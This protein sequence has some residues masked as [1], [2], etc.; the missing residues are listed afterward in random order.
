VGSYIETRA[1][2][3]H[4]KDYGGDGLPIVLVHGLGGS[5][6]SWN[7]IGPKLA[8]V[9]RTVAFDLPGFGLSPPGKDWELETHADAIV[10][11]IEELN[12]PATLVGNSLGA[13]LSEM[14]AASRP[15][16]VRGMVLISPATPPR[17]PDANIHWP[18]AFRLVLQATP[19]VG[20]AISKSLMKRL[21]P[22]RLV[23]MSLES[24]THK[25]SRI[26]MSIVNDLT[27]LARTRVR[28]P[29]TVQAVPVTGRSIAKL[30]MRPS[31]FVAMIR[32]IKA[33]TLVIQGVSDPLVSTKAVRWLCSLRPDWDHVEM[34]DTGHTPQLDT[35][36]RTLNV[37]LPW[38]QSLV[39]REIT[40]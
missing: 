7:A 34:E 6:P 5:I 33:P 27:A 22:E 30:F 26:P 13:L 36:M 9:G 4:W 20:P 19:G 16:L 17:L 1:G 15:E 3:L 10:A 14:V 2:S 11:L 38:I 28:L 25:S 35:P 29:W 12:G 21:T 23:H 32:M 18:T 39:K 31:R 8:T 24:I 37:M 40:A